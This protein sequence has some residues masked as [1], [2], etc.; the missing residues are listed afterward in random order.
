MSV[1]PSTKKLTW[2][3]GLSLGLAGLHEPAF[4]QQQPASA[5]R[6]KARPVET[7]S[8]DS[9]YTLKQYRRATAEESYDEEYEPVKP[10]VT[11]SASRSTQPNYQR[12]PATNRAEEPTMIKQ[13]G[14]HGQRRAPTMIDDPTLI[15]MDGGCTSCG[16]DSCGSGDCGGGGCL[17]DCL[18]CSYWGQNG[19]YVGAEYLYARATFSDPTAYTRRNLFFDANSNQR[20]T[21]QNV[22][23]DLEYQSALRAY[24][25]YRWGSCGESI[26]FGFFN[27][28]QST[29]LARAFADPPNGVGIAGPLEQNPGPL[30]GE[31][32]EVGLDVSATTYDID[33]SKRIPI[34]SCNSDACGCGDCPPWSITWNAGARIGDLE[35]NSPS[36]QFFAN[37]QMES[38]GNVLVEFVGAGPKMGIEGRRH[39]GQNY[40]WSAYGK[41]NI[42]LLLG[43]YDVTLTKFVNT[44]ANT[45]DTTQTFNYTR[46]VPV[47]D[48]EVGLS[49]QIGR[50]TLLTAGYFFQAWIDV[51]TV[52]TVNAAAF[53]AEAKIDGANITSFDGFMIRLERT[54]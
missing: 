52:N 25:G 41:S 5:K 51:S 37:G 17:N 22:T 33:Y 48:L 30:G 15:P 2:L 49:R 24:A 16:G 35:I 40:R 36:Q 45:I 38:Q 26:N 12:S 47:I 3:L 27:Y 13:V 54:F 43:Q 39:F 31:S 50:K 19:F 18:P 23:H 46:I 7:E 14:H 10:A 21:V 29:S 11:R 20:S 34:C 6:A 1:L 53:N 32:L 4:G 44:G 8:E 9:A 42:A 28:N